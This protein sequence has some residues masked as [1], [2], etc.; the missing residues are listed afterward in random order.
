MNAVARVRTPGPDGGCVHDPERP[1]R[2][3]P[4]T[5]GR[6]RCR[7]TSAAWGCTTKPDRRRWRGEPVA[8]VADGGQTGVAGPLGRRAQGAFCGLGR[9]ER[10]LQHAPERAAGPRADRGGERDL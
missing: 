3:Y 5:N 10:A 9:V 4:G 6:P 7:R 1:K 8:A 2:R